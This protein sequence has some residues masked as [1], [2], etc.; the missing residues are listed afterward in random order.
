MA[1]AGVEPWTGSSTDKHQFRSTVGHAVI[2]T[3]S[4]KSFRNHLRMLQRAGVVLPLT[5]HPGVM[6]ALRHPWLRLPQHP[7]TAV[8]TTPIP[9][10]A[11]P[12]IHQ[13]TNYQKQ[14]AK[15]MYA[16]RNKTQVH[17]V[18]CFAELES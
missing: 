7:H 8:L 14:Q 2:I 6:R 9:K 3:P 16:A 15:L 12:R 5:R 11:M 13:Q 17:G 4:V 10:C 18:D 1:R